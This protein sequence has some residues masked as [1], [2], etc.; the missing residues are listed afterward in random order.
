MFICRECCV[1][2]GRGPCDELTTR[3]DESYRLWC[4]IVCDLEISWLR[5][6]WPIGGCRTKNKQKIKFGLEY[7]ALDFSL[8][9]VLHSPVSSTFARPNISLS[10]MFWNIFSLCSSLRARDQYKVKLSHNRSWRLRGGWNCGTS[11]LTMAFGRTKMADYLF[12]CK[13]NGGSTAKNIHHL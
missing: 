11:V 5:R 1:L 10:I 9:V 8:S 12:V 7:A 6:P 2:S 3:P 13:N 4:V